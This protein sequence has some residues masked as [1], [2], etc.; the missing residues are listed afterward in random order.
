MLRMLPGLA[1]HGPRSTPR[2]GRC[3]A[4]GAILALAACLLP[5]DARSAGAAE[6]GEPLE[7]A[8]AAD[9]T[10]AD[11][12]R[13]LRRFD[14]DE[15]RN[16]NFEATPKHWQRISGP[17]LPAYSRGVF[18]EAV[19]H[20]HAP[21]FRLNVE[22]GNV[23]Y[24]YAH[25]DLDV[26][27]GA[28]FR[29]VG[30]IRTRRIEHARAFIAAYLVDRFGERI[31]A[32]LR[33]SELVA[34]RPDVPDAW[35]RVALDV[36]GAHPQAA[37]MRLQVWVMQ[38]GIWRSDDGASNGAVDAAAVPTIARQDVQARAW[39]DD[40]SVY[41][42]PQTRLTFSD[43]AHLVRP[44]QPAALIVD[45]D[46]ATGRALPV[47]VSIVDELG[48]TVFHERLEIAGGVRA[49]RE[50]P[51]PSLAPGTYVARLRPQV[52][53]DVPLERQLQF[54]VLPDLGSA[55]GDGR[56]LGIDLSGWPAADAAAATALLVGLNA[57]AAKVRVP[58]LGVIDDDAKRA[59]LAE[60]SALLQSLALARIE[61]VG[62]ITAPPDAG[63][64]ALHEFCA[65]TPAWPALASPVLAQL[66][67]RITTWQ[68]G[69]EPTELDREPG[70][71]EALVSAVRAHLQRFNSLPELAR[72]TSVLGPIPDGRDIR[73]LWVP[74]TIPTERIPDY[75]DFLVNEDPA[76]RW[77]QLQLAEQPAVA[78]PQSVAD[79]ARRLVLTKALSP[80]RVWLSAPFEPGG[81][82]G[83]W[84]PTDAY[85]PLRTLVHYLAG[86]QVASVTRLPPDGILILF[87]DDSER[88]AHCAV[89]WTWC[90]VAETEPRAFYLGR[91]A[92]IVDL[93]GRRRA[94]E[95]SDGRALLTLTPTP[96]IIENVH[97]PSA[98]IATTF[99]VEPTHVMLQAGD[100]RPV[101]TFRNG[102]V[103]RIAGEVEVRPP[104]EWEVEPQRFRFDLA[105]GEAVA[106]RLSLTL[107]RR[108]LRAADE[109]DIRVEVESPG[110]AAL[111]FGVPLTIGLGDIEMEA[112]AG[113]DGDRLIVRQVVRNGS[114]STVSFD[115]FCQPPQRAQ[116]RHAF[117]NLVPGAATER[118]YAFEGAAA[119]RGG[120]VHV[121]IREIRGD[122]VVERLVDV[123]R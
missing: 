7:A 9:P 30:Y 32:S 25:T 4:A 122:R 52:A 17:G 86:K 105:P 51:L 5:G 64:P 123:P 120:R 116:A 35:Q 15:R 66:G 81:P 74:A 23:G 47:D 97:L 107:P 80:D 58:V 18:D 1:L 87:R 112:T 72:P 94:L 2:P 53:Y 55:A 71:S 59:Q 95:Q 84:Q 43:P 42:V 6:D 61:A 57:A 88:A 115:G 117:L 26:L 22:L 63:A 40:I 111:R 99:R 90:D 36:S 12:F 106:E 34:D 96:E 110:P 102:A 69:R 77:V 91:D 54:A 65:R 45:V 49:P 73:A 3:R 119:L 24:E 20:E 10:P 75:L 39:F 60:L 118:V 16:G 83:G 109:L 33:V 19:G 113:W 82:S 108:L 67:G 27:P 93:W 14:F 13:L 103:G 70:W 79:M 121:G 50:L 62:V 101:L 41:V 38:A 21:S 11:A 85:V 28:A 78:R 48:A 114:T 37:S 31:D 89:A 8:A 100:A 29:V 46:N 92:A 98:L 76:P 56:D 104:Q 44:Q 68:L